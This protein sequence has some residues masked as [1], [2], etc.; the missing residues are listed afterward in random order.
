MESAYKFVML[1]GIGSCYDWL[2]S[3]TTQLWRVWLK[4]LTEHLGADNQEANRGDH[5]RQYAAVNRWSNEIK[6][7]TS[8]L[9]RS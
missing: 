9:F 3:L 2:K 7:V 4:I 6:W 1:I 8:P 5:G